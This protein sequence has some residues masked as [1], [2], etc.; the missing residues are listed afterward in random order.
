[1]A[2][3]PALIRRS[4]AETRSV[5][6][7]RAHYEVEQALAK[8]LREAPYE[9]R[10]T[11]Y[12]QVYEELFASVPDHP[13]LVGKSSP[14]E[15]AAEVAGQVATLKPFLGGAE[16]G[17]FLEIGAGD[18]AL[19][20]ELAPRFAAVHA[21]D[22][23]ETIASRSS[24]PDN[25]ELH[26][27][28]G[29]E[30]PVEEG[31]VDLAFSNQLLEHLH[32]DD[33]LAQ[34]RSVWRSLRSGGAYVC[35][36]PNRLSGPHDI[37]MFFDDAP[38]GFHLREYSAGELSTLFQKAGFSRVKVLARLPGRFMPAPLGPVTVLEALLEQLS[39][40]WRRRFARTPP[41]RVAF[42]RVVAFR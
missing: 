23:A 22:V 5:D 2:G 16:G 29:R 20:I 36:T 33:A 13:Q 3:E 39:P 24:W 32:P 11:L 19:S 18:C 8:R 41:A 40:K 9:E 1:L 15:R 31:S 17:V 7:L 10:A 35:L 27:T 14:A 12:S 30:I 42:G 38:T 37:S 26:I 6:R 34:T 28:D 21:I 25:V 4:S